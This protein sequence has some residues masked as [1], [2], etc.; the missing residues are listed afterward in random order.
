MRLPFQFDRCGITWGGP[1][2]DW[3]YFYP[4]PNFLSKEYRY[5]GLQKYWF[6]GPH[7]SFGFWFFNI[8]WCTQWS[9]PPIE[10]CN[11]LYQRRYWVRELYRAYYKQKALEYRFDWNV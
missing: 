3:Y 9:V 11:E 2:R 6:D 1:N 7:I 5:W 10:F 4:V 8:T